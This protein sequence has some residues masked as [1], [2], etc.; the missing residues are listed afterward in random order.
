[1][2][3]FEA[4][5]I[6]DTV[7]EGT[8]P[9]RRPHASRGA[10]VP[11]PSTFA[12]THVDVDSWIKA[13]ASFGASRAVLVV[14]HGCGFNTFPSQTK[15]PEFGFEYNYTVANSGWT[16]GSG[17]VAKDFVTACKKYGIKPGFYHGAMNNA[18]LNVIG[19]IVRERDQA[20]PWT[21]KITQ[22]SLSGNSVTPRPSY[23]ESAR[24]H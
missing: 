20:G 5:G 1:M 12:P 22:A 24:G 14:S 3:T 4:C 16:S 19:G 11:P 8:G 21:P 13:L 7:L 2:G 15:F 17:D 10:T 23:R 18:F 9:L 6:G